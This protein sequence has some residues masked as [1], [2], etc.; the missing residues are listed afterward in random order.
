L[1]KDYAAGV[2]ERHSLG[3]EARGQKFSYT[4]DTLASG[5]A[6]ATY[7]N[8]SVYTHLGQLWQGPLAGGSTQYQ[9]LYCSSSQPHQLTGLYGT[10]AT[11]SNKTG[12]GY[13]SSY[14]GFGNVTSRTFSGTTGTLTYDLLD[15]LTQW[16]ASSTNQEQYLYDASG[17]RVLRRFTNGNGTTILTYPFGI[18][19]HQYN[20]SGSNQWNVSYYFLAGR[21][22]GSLDGNGTQFYL[23]DALGSLVSDFNK[24]A[25][26]AALKGN[27]LFGP[28]G[29]G[30][31]YAG[32]IN[33]AKGFIGQ[34]NDG[35]G[36]DYLNA[37]YYDP[38]VGVFLSADSKQGNMQGMNPYAYVN[39][40]PETY[41]DPTGLRPISDCPTG[42]CN[43]P[44]DM[45][46][47]GSAGGSGADGAL[48]SVG[49]FGAGGFGAG[50]ALG[51]AGGSNSRAAGI[52][53][54][55]ARGI[56]SF[57]ASV[58]DYSNRN[59]A[60]GIA[61]FTDSADRLLTL[62]EPMSPFPI[63]SWGLQ[64]GDNPQ[65]HS[66]QLLLRYWQFVEQSQMLFELRAALSLN[67]GAQ[68]HLV[69]FTQYRPCDDCVKF[70]DRFMAL[71][72][73]ELNILLRIPDPV[74]P[75]PHITEPYVG[76]TLDV[77]TS[78]KATGKW[79][80]SVLYPGTVNTPSDITDWYHDDIYLRPV[81]S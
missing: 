71:M 29:T 78:V 81:V 42:G 25:G 6:G 33:T 52:A 67:I 49:G 17:E 21:L 34:Y 40:N 54:E 75:L 74:L 69:V 39:G 8:S 46:A 44:V 24:A 32:N 15:H 7:S 41:S 20:G 28:Y 66:E 57:R 13:A 65:N 64:F 3:S 55:L 76:I 68:L 23:V 37:R 26:G 14:D 60:W 30:R 11:C 53:Y 73:V 2:S 80:P 51:S 61:Y 19:E 18:E 77:Y 48:G 38:V 10:S 59:Y 36:L 79:W 9:Y 56:Q 63:P 45:G 47:L 22:L 31:Y 4:S 50:G 62:P 16:Y 58:R 12:Q 43:A 1:S 27:Q 70:F 5:L 72:T 35:T